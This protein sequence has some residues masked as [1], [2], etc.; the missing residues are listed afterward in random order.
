MEKITIKF[1]EEKVKAFE[2]NFRS[3]GNIYRISKNV[4]H[5]TIHN[6]LPSKKIRF[7]G[8]YDFYVNYKTF[9]Y[10]VSQNSYYGGLTYTTPSK[11]HGWKEM[12]E[13]EIVFVE[14]IIARK[15][16]GSYFYDHDA[17]NS[18]GMNLFSDKTLPKYAGNGFNPHILRWN[19]GCKISLI[20]NPILELDKKELEAIKLLDVIKRKNKTL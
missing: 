16:L 8:H 1:L 11:E 19:D 2:S 7:D 5:F 13:H 20:C 9:K 18:R 14:H 4:F 10:L 12:N 6:F 17:V 15:L 3:S